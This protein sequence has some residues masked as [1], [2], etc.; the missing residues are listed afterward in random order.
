MT[1]EKQ[2]ECI[3]DLLQCRKSFS[4]KKMTEDCNIRPKELNKLMEQSAQHLHQE[5]DTNKRKEMISVS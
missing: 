3:E 2:I 1:E 5:N 4:T